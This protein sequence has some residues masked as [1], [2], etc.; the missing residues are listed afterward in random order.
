[1]ARSVTGRSATGAPRRRALATAVFATVLVIVPTLTACSGNPLDAARDQIGSAVG[2]ALSDATGVDVETGTDVPADFPA[3]VPLVAGEVTAGGSVSANGGTTWSVSIVAPDAVGP[4]FAGIRAAL[5]AAGNVENVAA[6]TADSAN[7]VFSG[8][9]SVVVTL[10]PV[11]A[12]TE[13]LYV[14]TP[15]GR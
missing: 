14:V 3:S 13:V 2:D 10:K 6:E 12:G 8:E 5:V 15:I 4:T 7:G 1:M 9:F 11:D